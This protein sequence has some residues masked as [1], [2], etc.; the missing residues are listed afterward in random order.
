MRISV[1]SS[2]WRTGPLRRLPKRLSRR[3]LRGRSI[4]R[5]DPRR[6]VRPDG[7]LGPVAAAVFDELLEL[8]HPVDEALGPGRTTGDVDVDRH[9][10]I[11]PLDRRI[12]PLVPPARAGAVTHRD[13]PLRFRQL[14]PQ[15]E[16][17][18]GRLDRDRPG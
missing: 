18:A 2:R 10:P 11:D 6:N 4:R 1:V 13:A 5:S 3:T 8:H 14:L 12:A 16:E 7:P 17:R 9:D 15:P